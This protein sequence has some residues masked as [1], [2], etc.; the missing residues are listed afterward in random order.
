[1]LH[2]RRNATAKGINQEVI[3]GQTM[4]SSTEAELLLPSL[5]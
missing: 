3:Q 5:Q 4:P 1:M 2:L